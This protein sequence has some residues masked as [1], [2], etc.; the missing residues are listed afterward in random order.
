MILWRKNVN[1]LSDVNGM[2]VNIAMQI[3]QT[4]KLIAIVRCI[5]R[6]LLYYVEQ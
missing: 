3:I 4:K 1:N 5:I 2:L 6:N